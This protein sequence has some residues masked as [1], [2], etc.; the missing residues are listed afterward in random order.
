M[1]RP[2]GPA[3]QDT[4]ACSGWE[5]RDALGAGDSKRFHAVFRRVP[6]S[7]TTVD[8][9]LLKLGLFKNVRIAKE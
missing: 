7:A 2:V 8:L 1:Q 3:E 4:C 9:D 6:K 5:I